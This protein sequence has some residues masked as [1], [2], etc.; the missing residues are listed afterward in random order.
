[1][2]EKLYILNRNGCGNIAG[3]QVINLNKVKLT[4]EEVIERIAEH[5]D[6]NPDI[7]WE[8]VSDPT[9]IAVL[10]IKNTSREREREHRIDQLRRLRDISD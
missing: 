6:P 7:I 2:S 5:N 3:Y 10:E 9:L 8:R 1:M 4:K